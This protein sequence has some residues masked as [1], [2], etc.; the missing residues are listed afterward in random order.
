[1]L[2]GWIIGLLFAALNSAQ[3]QE[4]TTLLQRGQMAEALTMLEP[5]A[6]R[7]TDDPI[8]NGLLGRARL[9][10]GDAKGAIKPLKKSLAQLKTD[11][12]GFSNLGV[13][14]MQTKQT[15]EAAQAFA[16]A[17]VLMPRQP[18]AWRNLA[19]AYTHLSRQSD[20]RKA[21]KRYISFKPQDGE[22]RCVYGGLLLA[23]DQTRDAAVHLRFGSKTTQD[24]V[25]LHDYADAL[26]RLKQPKK[27]LEILDRLIRLDQRNAHAF[28]LRAYILVDEGPQKANQALQALEKSIK[29][30][31]KRAA[32]HHLNGYILERMERREE[33]L[34]AYARAVDLEPK[35][36]TYQQAKAVAS[37][38]ARAKRHKNHS[39]KFCVN[40]QKMM[41]FDAR[42]L[43][44]I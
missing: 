20:A 1:M 44:F 13:A 29:L 19:G 38:L 30:A 9:H 16:Q 35:N 28:Y 43:M 2:S 7:H 22:A 39:I 21:W 41:R 36:I 25:C 5:L 32:S 3:M 6:K 31:P 8:I 17:V 27:A 15:K 26:G 14:F 40:S 23:S 12:E 10:A 18:Q 37:V 34:L 11:G 4:I 24:I 42:W 33:A